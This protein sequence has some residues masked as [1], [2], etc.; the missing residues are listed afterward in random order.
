MGFSFGS[1]KIQATSNVVD[2]F[3]QF[4]GAERDKVQAK[5]ES[6]LKSDRQRL[7]AGFRE[8]K[9]SFRVCLQI[10]HNQSDVEGTS[11]VP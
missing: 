5:K 7:M 4:M 1:A 6:M 8:F 3:R 11:S 10:V 2:Q 9:D